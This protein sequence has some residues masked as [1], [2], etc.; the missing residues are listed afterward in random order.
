MKTTKIWKQQHTTLKQQHTVLDVR[1]WLDC[2][3]LPWTFWVPWT[4]GVYRT[5]YPWSNNVDSWLIKTPHL[6]W[7]PSSNYWVVY[8]SRVYITS[9][10]WIISQMSL[11]VNQ[12]LMNP[13]PIP[14]LICSTWRDHPTG[15]YLRDMAW[16]VCSSFLAAGPFSALCSLMDLGWFLGISTSNSGWG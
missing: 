10:I 11:K 2:S 3:C 4:V 8:W 5:V 16:S 9:V 15:S 1:T 7:K 6:P 12:P 14:L 13:P